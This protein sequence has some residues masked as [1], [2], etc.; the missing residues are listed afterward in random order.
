[1]WY[2][3][4]RAQN[5]LILFFSFIGIFGA[6]Y[7]IG[8]PYDLSTESRREIEEAVFSHIFDY[9]TN[10]PE[11]DID[12]F[13]IGV[14]GL[15]PSGKILDSFSEKTPRVEPIS[16]SQTSISLKAHVTHKYHPDKPGMLVNLEISEVKKN[17]EVL[18]KGHLYQN[19]IL[20][21]Q[22]HFVLRKVD[23]EYI[24]IRTEFPD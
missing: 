21:A 2:K 19:R 1:M 9:L 6:L 22:Y 14:S 10:H 8:R 24:V 16:S 11:T 5:T 23:K 7:F 15:D 18:V 3:N 4:I 17:G 20:S 12:Y 13:F